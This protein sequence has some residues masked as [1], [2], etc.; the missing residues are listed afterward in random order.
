MGC[1]WGARQQGDLTSGFL[2]SGQEMFRGPHSPTASSCRQLTQ[3]LGFW[4]LSVC[5]SESSPCFLDTNF[6]AMFLAFH[7]LPFLLFFSTIE[8][9]FGQFKAQRAPAWS[10]LG[11]IALSLALS[12]DQHICFSFSVIFIGKAKLN[13]Q[14]TA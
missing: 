3:W 6:D 14:I 10:A 1:R 9:P 5:R 11:N 7:V 4:G 13:T 8:R 12:L 2:E